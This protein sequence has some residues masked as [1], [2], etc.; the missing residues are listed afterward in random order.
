MGGPSPAWLETFDTAELA[1]IAEQ[2]LLRD[3]DS[4]AQKAWV[5]ENFP[6][7]AGKNNKFVSVRKD[8]DTDA[9]LANFKGY[10]TLQ[11]I[12]ESY[13][14]SQPN[15]TRELLLNSRFFPEVDMVSALVFPSLVS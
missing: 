2:L 8:K 9:V 11:T 7:G 14:P 5:E 1:Y 4:P 10:G 3:R 6:G 15:T 12:H 13:H